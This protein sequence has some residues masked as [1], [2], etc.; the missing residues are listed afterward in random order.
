MMNVTNKGKLHGKIAVVTGASRLNGIGAA[1][2]KELAKEGADIFFTYWKQYDLQF[3]WGVQDDEPE[4]L[5]KQLVETGV[6]CHSMELDL[7]SPTSAKELFKAVKEH[8][9]DPHIVV[10]NACYSVSDT[11]E[12]ISAAALDA[13][14]EINIRAAVLLCS[15][16]VKSFNH[17]NGGRIINM[18][19]G[20]SLGPM[21]GE[22]SYA[23]TKGA[24]ETLTYTLAAAVA[25]KKIT[26]NAVN[27]GPTDTGWMD[28]T[29]K[30][31]I[32]SRFPMGR[33]G[34]PNDA[35]RLIAY[36]ASDDAEWVTGQI[37]HSEGGFRR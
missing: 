29:I 15:E 3:P 18:S 31:S 25:H 37:I 14:Y 13:H 8:L 23:I 17:A 26:V 9:G 28:E 12:N 2:C 34:Q 4:Q 10:N 22:L 27:P 19:S 21:T 5:K 35:A 36:L 32:L 11:I 1:I 6:H 24:V 30:Q 20:Q 7:S 33:I 16:F